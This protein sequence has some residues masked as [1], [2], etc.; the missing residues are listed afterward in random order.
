MTQLKA[1]LDRIRGEEAGA[2][3]ILRATAKMSDGAPMA[4][5]TGNPHRVSAL[6]KLM[7]AGLLRIEYETITVNSAVKEI[8][9]REDPE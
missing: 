6:I 4:E 5:F 9:K 8:L 7:R 1:T 3:A 2:D